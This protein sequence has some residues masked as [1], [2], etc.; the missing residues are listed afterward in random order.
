MNHD[1]ATGTHVQTEVQQN[2]YQV[3]SALWELSNVHGVL[4]IPGFLF[5]NYAKGGILKEPLIY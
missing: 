1:H 5:A 2:A 3:T 4:K